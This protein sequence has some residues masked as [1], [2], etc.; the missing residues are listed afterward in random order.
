M[1]AQDYLVITHGAALA[2]A[3]ELGCVNDGGLP[4]GAAGLPERDAG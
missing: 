4:V 3:E 2:V 1:L